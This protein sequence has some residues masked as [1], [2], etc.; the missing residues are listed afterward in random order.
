MAESRVSVVIPAFNA[1]GT[2]DRAIRS[3][4]AQTLPPH[5]VIVVD[6]GSP[7][8]TAAHVAR[9]YPESVRLLRQENA[10]PG[11]ARNTGAAAATGEWLAFLDADDAWL[12]TKLERQMRETVAP[13]VGVVACRCVGQ[14]QPAF[15]AAPDFDDLWESNRIAMSSSLVRRAAFEQAGGLWNRLCED[16]HLWLRLTGLGWTI[17]NC[18]EELVIYAPSPLSLSR[19]IE[20]FAEDEIDCLRD[21][22]EQFALPRERVM[23]RLAA[24]CLRHSR[25]AVHYRQMTTA[26]RLAVRSLRYAVSVPQLATLLL[27]FTPAVLLDARRRMLGVPAPTG[28]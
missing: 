4:L 19:R 20:R 22:A 8:D 15:L 10:G 1:L 9:H 27:A 25:G 18:P 17:V 24:S 2:I 14:R 11:I 13:R 7:D 21:V 23:P 16:Y 28:Q 5:E 6:D 26:R 12:P 3:A